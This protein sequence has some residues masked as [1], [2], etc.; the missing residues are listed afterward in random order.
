[1]LTESLLDPLGAQY[2]SKYS[3]L[4]ALPKAVDV[5]NQDLSLL[6]PMN[7]IFVWLKGPD[8][9][10]KVRKPISFGLTLPGRLDV[11]RS[12]TIYWKIFLP[13]WQ[14]KEQHSKNLETFFFLTVMSKLYLLAWNTSSSAEFQN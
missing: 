2:T 6:L 14:L 1:M 10:Y 5:L 4:D 7:D 8:L 13:R 9:H 11:L 12:S 3:R